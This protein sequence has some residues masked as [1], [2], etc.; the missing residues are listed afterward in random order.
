MSPELFEKKRIYN[1]KVDIWS[2]GCVIYE[3]IYLKKFKFSLNLKVNETI[4][5]SLKMLLKKLIKILKEQLFL[6]RAR[7]NIFFKFLIVLIK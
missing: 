2:L 7:K 3:L 4:S 1:Q 5:K 6:E